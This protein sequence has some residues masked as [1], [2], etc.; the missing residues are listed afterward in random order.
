[1]RKLGIL[2]LVAVLAVSLAAPARAQDEGEKKW[3]IHGEVRA[4][5]DY[6]EN[7]DYLDVDNGGVDDN[8]SIWPYMV[9]VSIDG[10]IT[11]NVKAMVEFRNDGLFGSAPTF[12]EFGTAPWFYTSA[13]SSEDNVNLYQGWIQI[14]QLFG[15]DS[16]SARVG[17]QEMILGTELLLGDN[18][19]YTGQSY[20]GARLMWNHETW[21][22]NA[23]Y[24]K[25][26]ENNFFNSPF[27]IPVD[28]ES[29]DTNLLGAAFNYK[30]EGWGGFDIYMLRYQGLD[31]YF[32]SSL[33]PGSGI[34]TY[35][36]RW[37]NSAEKGLFDWNIEYAIQSGDYDIPTGGVGGPTTNVDL[38]SDVIEGWLGVNFRPGNSH[39]RFNVGYLAA[40]GDDPTT[41]DD[42][43]FFPL[44]GDSNEYNRLGNLDNFGLSNVEDI[45]VAYTGAFA[46]GKHTFMLAVHQLALDQPF[47]VGGEDDLGMAWD[48][49]YM[50]QYN[51]MVGLEV[52]VSQG[53]PGDYQ[54][55][56]VGGSADTA[57]RY[58]AQ[59]NVRW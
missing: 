55:L 9:R 31:D 43:T 3:N 12:N 32:G 54:D 5:A 49:N 33:Y 40:S 45:S 2:A 29:F 44:F 36:A 35:G 37:G 25:L 48:L 20:D 21:S 57:S 58:Y 28:G 17:R 51:K 53:M 18:D 59:L 19:F 30:T 39:H 14:D 26:V 8:A 41:T 34:D 13:Y 1:M 7:Y 42:E 10:T 11:D 4:R 16:F 46:E 38:S 15:W 50:Y 6:F 47:T 22:I 23:F 56:A 24:F 27:G 52:N